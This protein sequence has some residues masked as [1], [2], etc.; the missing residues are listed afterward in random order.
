MVTETGHTSNTSR[1]E[2]RNAATPLYDLSQPIFQNAPQW[3][4]Y[5]PATVT[6]PYTIAKNGFNAE[7]VDLMTHTG[8]HVD[9]PF[10]VFSGGATIDAIPLEQF[11]GLAVCLDLRGRP[12][13][14]TIGRADLE[15]YAKMLVKDDIVLLNTGWGKKRSLSDE[16]L[17]GW[18]YLDGPGAEYLVSLGVKGVGT[19]GLSIG[20]WGD[21]AKGRPAHAALLGAEKLVIED[22]YLPEALLDG[23]RRNFCAFPIL[24]RGCGGAWVRAVAWDLD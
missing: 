23:K 5:D 21:P 2:H 3:A 12:T 11:I 9:V 6:L 19:D 17:M 16:Y 20:G 4:E 7:R 13:G 8:T 18:P 14:S 22:M 10:H 24:L 1:F 15:P